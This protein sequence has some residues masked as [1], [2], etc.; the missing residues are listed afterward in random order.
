MSSYDRQPENKLPIRG[1]KQEEDD[2]SNWV[3]EASPQAIPGTNT[4][5]GNKRIV[6]AS[7]TLILVETAFLSSAASLIWLINNYFP[8]GPVLRIFFPIPIALV[9]LRWGNRASWMS[10][11]VSGLLLS[12]LMGPTR[13]IMFLMPYGLMG[14]QLGAMWKRQANWLFS[15]I[16]GTLIGTFGFFFRFWLVSIFIGED[17]WIYLIAQFTQLAEWLFLQLG[18]LAVPSL[19]VIEAIALVMVLINNII[20]LFAVHLVALLVMDRLGNPIPRP[21]YWV[22]VLLDYE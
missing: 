22:Q 12:V 6:G 7:S 20:Y 1:T 17:L 19:W 16:L 18:L 5:S 15:I 10:A 13:S 2:D 4:D 8:I 21:P 14:V 9:Y 3:D 11:I